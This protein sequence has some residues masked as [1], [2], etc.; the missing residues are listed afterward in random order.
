MLGARRPSREGWAECRQRGGGKGPGCPTFVGILALL[1][2]PLCATGPRLSEALEGKG[3]RARGEDGG[4]EGAAEKR[5][6]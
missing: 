2:E 3:E 6:L 4:G 5:K 1:S